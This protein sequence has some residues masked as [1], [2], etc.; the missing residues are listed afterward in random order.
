ME[1]HPGLKR[2]EKAP[3]SRAREAFGNPPPSHRQAAYVAQS[4][5][6]RL[7]RL[8]SQRDDRP[9]PA[10]R[11]GAWLFR[12]RGHSLAP[13]ALLIVGTAVYVSSI[14]AAMTSPWRGPIQAAA[15]LLLSAAVAIRFHVAGHAR[16]GTS[17]RGVTFEAGE[18]I[19]TGTYAI[20]RNPLYV[21]NILIWCGIAMMT[22][23][24]PLVA[25][26]AVVAGLQYHFII[27][28]EE[29]YLAQRYGRRY[30]EYQRCVPRWIPWRVRRRSIPGAAPPAPFT[31]SRGLFREAD[32]LFLLILGAWLIAGLSRG[33]TPWHPGAVVPRG[34]YT[35]PV[36][37]AIAWAVVKGLKR[38]FWKRGRRPAA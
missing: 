1:T 3:G 7:R 2:P 33:W 20:V 12:H 38:S 4:E 23:Y 31:W 10:E 25:L 26:T 35:L 17:S 18:L 8:A 27:K 22:G 6:L 14:S 34:W 30:A 21:A 29:R 37:P 36:W 11:L 32:T 16:R 15:V 13:L 28:A 19:T 5:T 9:T 24:L